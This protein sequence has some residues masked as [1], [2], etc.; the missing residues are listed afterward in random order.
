MLGEVAGAKGAMGAGALIGA[1]TS[2]ITGAFIGPI[3]GAA[4]G[5]SIGFITKSKTAQNV[6]FGELDEDKKRKGG[7]FSKEIS[8]FIYDHV[9]SMAKGGVAGLV[10]GTLLGSPI[11]GAI[12]GTTVGYVSS[13]EQAKK[14]L[15]GEKGKDGKREG[16]LISKEFT[17]KIKKA[18]P[19]M[20]GG[21][22][23]MTLL[24]PAVPGGLVG[25]LLVGSA[26]GFATTTDRFQTW[27]FGKDKDGKYNK[28]GKGGFS[29]LVVEKLFNPITDL[30][31]NL[32]SLISGTIK[33]VAG[34]IGK[35]IRNAILKRMG[36]R[37]VRSRVGRAVTGGL[38]RAVNG[39][40]SLATSPVR[41]LS[42]LA[43]SR[44][45][46]RGYDAYQNGELMTNEQRMAYRRSHPSLI[47]FVKGRN[48]IENFDKR[49]LS[50][51]RGDNEQLQEFRDTMAGMVDWRGQY[52]KR[53]AEDRKSS[54]EKF[55]KALDSAAGNKKL[56]NDI[57][58]LRK[59]YLK[60]GG[61]IT[62]KDKEKAI[63]ELQRIYQT[64]ES[65]TKEQYDELEQEI[66][67]QFQTS[68]DY[69][70]DEFDNGQKM[71]KEL[72]GKLN[73]SQHNILGKFGTFFDYEKG[74][75][76]DNTIKKLMHMADIEIANNNKKDAADGILQLDIYRF[77]NNICRG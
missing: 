65:F 31:R 32:T 50:E 3:A 48:R 52:E 46:A 18:V 28:L 23:L 8:N 62:D 72:L 41:G 34:S 1:G 14:L 6:L 35:T 27:F 16:G 70:N 24:G 64:Y 69:G 20:A 45:L 54:Q 38:G 77:A 21:A 61:R 7:V 75:L 29:G 42:N 49:F 13:S 73:D 5:A 44:A 12:A 17:D 68:E 67:R 56:E 60:K 76:S 58:K 43:R 25:K 36:R 22:A 26:L 57:I 63:A 9:P 37:L 30:F 19:S 66:E 33:D 59:K 74:E 39:A 55:Q 53:M 51:I 4:V 40:F 10:G 15:F 2:L 47:R 11:L 71:R